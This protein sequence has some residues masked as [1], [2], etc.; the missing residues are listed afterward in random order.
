MRSVEDPENNDGFAVI[1]SLL[2]G[3]A[4]VIYVIYVVAGVD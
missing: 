4:L 2:I 1:I 3:L